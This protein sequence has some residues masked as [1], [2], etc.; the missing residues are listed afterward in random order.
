M[1]QIIYVS[2]ASKPFTPDEL[3]ELLRQARAKN[4][5]L[6]ITGLLL[7]KDGNFIQVLEGP[8]QAVA[9][10]YQTIQRDLRHKTIISMSN[11]QIEAREF[12]DWEMGFTDIAA[13]TEEDK[14]GLST[15]LSESMTPETLS[16]T[17]TRARILLQSFRANMR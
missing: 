5:R 6:D 15:F 11:R 9:D 12:G 4:R 10:L 1:R 3:A 13:L 2:S 7:Y 14:P 16:L 8:D 17:P